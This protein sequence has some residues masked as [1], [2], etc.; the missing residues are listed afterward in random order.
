MARTLVQYDPELGYRYVPGLRA[1]VPHEGGAYL[2]SVNS[3]GF[4]SD[5]EF[6]EQRTPGV[7]RILAFG[8]SFTAG[9]GVRNDARYTAELERRLP[10]TEVFNFGLDG[11]GTDQQYLIY[12]QV[13][14]RIEHDLLLIAPYAE[15][16]RRNVATHHRSERT[17]DGALLSYPKPYFTLS[18]TGS[19]VRHHQP[20]PR[21]PEPLAT[22]EAG[23]V[24]GGQ[25][26]VLR[27]TIRRVGPRAKGLAQRVTRYQPLPEYDEPNGQ[28]WRLM[29]AVLEA[30][31]SDSVVP[32]VIAPIPMHQYIE[33]TASSEAFQARMSELHA[34]P[35]VH[36]VDLLKGLRQYS[37]DERR[38][39]RFGTDT[40]LTPAGH[41]AIGACLARSLVELIK[42]ESVA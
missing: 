3:E 40:H 16:I 22:S 12:K 24:S 7:R 2:V 5:Y 32:V 8:D 20:V 15:N 11:S 9:Y 38:E 25:H 27:R 37:P 17:V 29:R 19:L 39:F 10:G 18:E 42:E 36:V 28:A 33:E 41:A 31:V 30:W 6:L 21:D 14:A 13:S 35:R 23:V 26:E 1:R 34:P 4:R